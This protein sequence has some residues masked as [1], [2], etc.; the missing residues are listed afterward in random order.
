MVLVEARRIIPQKALIYNHDN[1]LP[2]KILVTKSHT[3][4][5]A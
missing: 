3:A 5:G 4:F 2:R 1:W